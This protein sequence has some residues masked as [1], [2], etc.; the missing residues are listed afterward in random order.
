M[1]W[2]EV[3][4]VMSAGKFP[5]NS[6]RAS[7]AFL[8]R[9]NCLQASFLHNI[10]TYSKPR[11][12]FHMQIDLC[13][14]LRY[15]YICFSGWVSGGIHTTYLSINHHHHRKQCKGKGVRMW[16]GEWEDTNRHVQTIY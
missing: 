6:A 10:G 13:I 11:L 14:V 5:E 16:V 4:A 15:R 8:Y 1:V 3:A 9:L 2:H 12:K 7:R